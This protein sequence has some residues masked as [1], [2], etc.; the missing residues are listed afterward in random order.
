MSFRPLSLHSHTTGFTLPVVSQMSGQRSS[1]YLTRAVW[2]VPTLR[3]LVNR[4]GV[5]SV[6]SSSI[7]TRPVVLPKPF[8]THPAASTLSWYT[9]PGWGN[10][11]VTPVCT[12]PSARV[13][14]PTVTPATS[15]IL[16]RSPWGSCPIRMPQLASIPIIS[17]S[18]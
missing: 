16:F 1:I 13:Q 4:M 5:S 10:R 15:L 12:L 9:S 6:P 3:V 18:G 8:S 17:S 14:W 11:A 2:T 7:C